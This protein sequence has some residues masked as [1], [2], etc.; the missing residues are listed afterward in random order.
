MNS[1]SPASNPPCIGIIKLDTAFPRLVGDVG[2]PRTF[3][4]PVRYETVSGASPERVVKQADPS[5]LRPFLQAAR[6]LEASGVTALTTSCGFL[7]IYQQE[8]ARAVNIPVFSSSLLQIHLAG[9][10]IQ[11]GQ[12][13]GIITADSLSLTPAH[14]SGLGLAE[15]PRAVV[16]LEEAE[17][18]SAV[19]LGN[20]P[21]LERRKLEQD[22]SLA[23]DELMRRF[24]EI[25]AVVLECTNMPPFAPIIRQK[26]GL[27]VFDVVSLI[28]YAY[29]VVS[30]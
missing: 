19:F 7:A 21:R 12:E 27:P 22:M 2:N 3:P 13:V 1:T 26:T 25:G 10:I 14:F 11:K 6:K 23:C 9:A 8:L 15:P 29:A 16:G 28:H 30:R 24:P 5:L 18:F 17:E 20:R 4:F